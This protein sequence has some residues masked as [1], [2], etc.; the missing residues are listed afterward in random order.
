MRK[1]EPC[2]TAPHERARPFREAG[3]TLIEMLVSLAV[4]TVALSVV[5][6]VF[7]VTTKTASQAAAYSEVHNWVRQ[8]EQ[9][10]KEDL[11]YVDPSRSVLVVIG[12]IVEASLTEADRQAGRY[13]RVWVGDPDPA[14]ERSYDPYSPNYDAF[15]YSPP[16]A[17]MIMFITNR[18][19]A[20]QAPPS[21]PNNAYAYGAAGGIKFGSAAVTY[22]HAALGD[23]VW[24]GSRFVFPN[25]SPMANFV[26]HIDQ[27]RI[28][29]SVVPA[30]QWHLSRV[31]RIMI[32]P[33]P[34]DPL[35]AYV[36]S[37]SSGMYGNE[38]QRT[39]RCEPDETR[40]LAGDMVYFNL[41]H[42][43]SA[44]EPDPTSPQGSAAL[45]RPYDGKNPLNPSR[46]FDQIQ[47]PG[48]TTLKN[49]ILSL[50]FA[51][52]ALAN[53]HIATVLT[54]V[55]AELRSNMG[56]QMLPGCAWF[57]V[58]FLM[59]EDPRNSVNYAEPFDPNNPNP[60]SPRADLTR[61]CEVPA[62]TEPGVER[63]YIFVPDTAAN[64]ELVAAQATW[65]ASGNYMSPL[66]RLADFARVDQNPANDR[67]PA[68][69]FGAVT[70]RVVRR[71]PYALRI[72][73]H[74]YD[75]RGRLP[76]P[77]I[78]TVVHRFE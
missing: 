37:Q 26:R 52:G 77:I 65:N 67:N 44:F 55:P 7:A 15:A 70:D 30:N 33:P 78:R 64:R 36:Y 22:G 53:H 56:V 74:A 4:L 14:R 76:E 58:E 8:W 50:M 49:S 21:A 72:T 28:G 43:L 54:E 13:H 1:A 68:L 75:P 10:I 29:R 18:P 27:E 62:S 66:G 6:V 9:Q 61:W 3:F 38:G 25:D 19:L 47:I 20:S 32:P 11:R 69:P 71:W 42:F 45:M 41:D 59:P 12:R 73:V 5:G 23:P 31:Q 60:V 39:G 2:D 46:T 16:R 48:Q 17:D 24:N 40:Q 63:M 35:K 34:T 57:Q 51:S